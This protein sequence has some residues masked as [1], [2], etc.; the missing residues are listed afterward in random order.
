M[1]GVSWINS[2]EVASTRQLT[3][4]I[5]SIPGIVCLTTPDIW[6]GQE[7]N[8]LVKYLDR[9]HVVHAGLHF[10]ESK[11]LDNIQAVS[12]N[13]NFLSP[14]AASGGYS[15]KAT[16]HFVSFARSTYDKVSGFDMEL[17]WVAAV[18]EFC[19]RVQLSGGLVIGISL[20]EA[21]KG[22]KFESVTRK[23][24]LR[25]ASLHLGP[26]PAWLL[27]LYYATHLTF[28]SFPK[29]TVGRFPVTLGGIVHNRRTR[30][31]GPYTAIIPTLL[32]YD[33]IERSIMSLMSGVFPPT[34][35]IVVDQT[36]REHRRTEIYRK[37]EDQGYVRTY[38]LDTAGQ[39]TARNLAI[40]K[41]KTEWLLFFEDDTE[42]WPDMVTEHRYLMEHS[43]ADVST[44]VSLAPWKDSSYIPDRLRR[45]HVSDVLATGNCFMSKKTALEVG[46]L[47]PAFNRGPGAD[48]DF[49]RRLF[50]TGKLIV[51]NYKAIQT[52]HKAVAG[53][54][55]VH[56][57]WW[58]NTSNL[59]GAYPPATQMFLIRKYYPSRMW[60]TQILAFY[61][62][63]RKR[64]GWVRFIASMLFLPL[65]VY[66]SHRLATRLEESSIR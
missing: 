63:S 61:L 22:S 4:R 62:W 3:E 32:R 2:F 12:L 47:H 16:P 50:I 23:D 30:R 14:A 20:P 64:V 19:Y 43:F 35:I 8:E 38:F 7:V 33:Y 31:V 24:T 60:L 66:K 15:W 48:D 39:S 53:G 42:A 40:Q 45:Y 21:D 56:R 5:S 52:H 44:G 46:G 36:P 41:A 34:E 65:K 59:L 49:G 29:R 57:T 27:W 51:F 9:V 58:R 11:S 54:M 28:S 6:A 13:W 26:N 10:S 25:F 1:S 37:H 18:M 55:R 17:G